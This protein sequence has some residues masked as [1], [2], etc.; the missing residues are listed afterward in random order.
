MPGLNRNPCYNLAYKKIK[1]VP[2]NKTL[3]RSY[4]IYFTEI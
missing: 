2:Y 1:N 3:R 4:G